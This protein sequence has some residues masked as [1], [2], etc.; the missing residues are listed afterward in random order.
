MI[1]LQH[2]K[3]QRLC[4]ADQRPYSQS[5]GFSSSHVWMW[6]L[7]FKESWA[8]KN[9]CF[10]TVKRLLRVLWTARRS[11]QL[12]LK[13][14]NPE[15]SLEGLMLKLKF[16]HFGHLMWRVNSLEQTLMLGK[17][18]GKRRGQQRMRWLDDIITST[19]MNLR[20]LQEMVEDREAW[21][22]TVHWVANSWT[23]LSNWTTTKLSLVRIILSSLIARIW[24]NYMKRLDSED[25]LTLEKMLMYMNQY[26][27]LCLFDNYK[28]TA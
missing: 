3:K 18:E 24:I 20:K 11:N 7:D 1:N 5:Y 28:K 14:I 19:D 16:Q 17:T 2:I 6:E 21:H 12:I 26:P 25:F 23:W 15:Y 8:E 22:A 13:E 10:W 4:F 9:G 27:K